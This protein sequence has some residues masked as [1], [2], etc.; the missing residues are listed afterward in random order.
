MIKLRD[1]QGVE[2]WFNAGQIVAIERVFSHGNP[3]RE[4]TLVT[5]TN[6]YAIFFSEQPDELVTM[7]ESQESDRPML[8]EVCSGL[9]GFE[10]TALIN[11]KNI[12]WAT[13]T[14]LPRI[15]QKKTQ[16]VKGISLHVGGK[17]FDLDMSIDEFRAKLKGCGVVI[18]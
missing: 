5:F 17:G 15:D 1:S 7:I 8:L 10:F 4:E 3:S 11:P 18:R 6:G 13:E 9:K 2:R 14:S 12:E 16:W